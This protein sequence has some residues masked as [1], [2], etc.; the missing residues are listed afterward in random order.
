MV[1]DSQVQTPLGLHRVKMCSALQQSVLQ[2]LPFF[3]LSPQKLSM[4]IIS[5]ISSRFSCVPAY[6]GLGWRICW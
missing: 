2:S 4:F 3:A 1:L 6:P 5:A